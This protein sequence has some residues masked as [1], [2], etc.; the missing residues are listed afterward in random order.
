MTKAELILT[1]SCV[2]SD[3]FDLL[4][5]RFYYEFRC[6][7]E[8]ESIRKWLQWAEIG[9]MAGTT[10][11]WGL[12]DQSEKVKKVSVSLN[13]ARNPQIRGNSKEYLE[14]YSNFSLDL[15]S[16]TK[17]LQTLSKTERDIVL[18]DKVICYNG[19]TGELDGLISLIK[20]NYA[21]FNRWRDGVWDS[22]GNGGSIKSFI[23]FPITLSSNKHKLEAIGAV[24]FALSAEN[25]DVEEAL[26]SAYR[27][28]ALLNLIAESKFS[29]DVAR[30]TESQVVSRITGFLDTTLKGPRKNFELTWNGWFNADHDDDSRWQRDALIERL[31]LSKDKQYSLDNYKGMF[32]TRLTE[33]AAMTAIDIQHQNSR[34]ILPIKMVGEVLSHFLAVKV[35]IE[36]NHD[37]EDFA[38]PVAPGWL[39][40]ASLADAF[41]DFGVSA[42]TASIRISAF[43]TVIPGGSTSV[44]GFSFCLPSR[45]GSDSSAYKLWSCL[46]NVTRPGATTRR[47][48]QLIHLKL[49]KD[50][51]DFS[52]ELQADQIKKVKWLWDGF[53]VPVAT[54]L[55]T[56][57]SQSDAHQG[58]CT[59]KL[60][61][62]G[63]NLSD[64]GV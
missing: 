22:V 19:E 63:P 39:F 45:K 5:D 37:L 11:T 41:N 15:F 40:L 42:T 61:W 31:H 16:F 24:F 12:I 34:R 1:E 8:S 47:L 35:D 64:I 32:E 50:E 7:V 59:V 6:L 17:V 49:K 33:D 36:L 48:H 10:P 21:E 2:V 20:S 46:H 62:L 3:E 56:E 9:L 57:R 55:V 29:K 58:C 43:V 53:A 60:L 38:L 51:Y 44:Y 30:Y 26:R 14:T 52:R 54:Y 4:L 28:R 23:F 27:I 13:I 18:H 25:E